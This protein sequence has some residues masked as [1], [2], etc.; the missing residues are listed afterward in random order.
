MKTHS[1]RFILA[2][3]VSVGLFLGLG[4]T[5]TAQEKTET[6]KID[7]VHSNALFRVKHFGAGYVFGEFLGEKGE[8]KFNPENPEQTEV[9]LTIPVDSIST[10][11]T[12]RDKHLKSPDFFDAKQFPNITFKSKNVEKRTDD[13]FKVTG[14]LTIHGKTKEVSTIVQMVGAGED[15]QG[16]YRRGF[17]TT[18]NIDRS[19]FGIDY[20]SGGVS[21]NVKLIIAVEG[22]RQ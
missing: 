2:S 5:A 3:L 16:N 8:I 13:S 1:F 9:N 17:Y 15:P 10:D 12:K 7:P 20:M 19:D 14:D 21:D 22:V 6:Y 11:N 18:F 4:A